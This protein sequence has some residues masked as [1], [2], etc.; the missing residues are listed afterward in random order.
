MGTMAP[1]G[2]DHK[3]CEDGEILFFQGEPDN[4]LYRLEGGT[5][6]LYIMFQKPKIISVVKES[7][8]FGFAP[9]CTG[10]HLYNAEVVGAARVEIF[11]Y[12]PQEHAFQDTYYAGIFHDLKQFCREKLWGKPE[13]EETEMW[14][15]V[16]DLK[17]FK[18]SFLVRFFPFQ[19]VI[20][21]LKTWVS[22][23]K[24]Q[25]DQSKG[26]YRLVEER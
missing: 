2:S 17:A 15:L 24:L 12:D 23:G 9:I 13:T 21:T 18:E 7:R 11:E 26:S 10:Y 4:R 8:F 5:I 16:S 22:E 19:T 6:L 20:S 14:R 1:A 3:R 25:Q